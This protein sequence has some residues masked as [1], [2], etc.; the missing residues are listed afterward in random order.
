MKKTG[1]LAVL[2]LVLAML[3][4]V[5]AF[6]SS[7][8]YTTKVLLNSNCSTGSTLAGEIHANEADGNSYLSYRFVPSPDIYD[9]SS[10]TVTPAF[11][12]DWSYLTLDFD[13]MTETTYESGRGTNLYIMTRDAGNGPLGIRCASVV[14]NGDGT[15]KLVASVTG[16]TY[17]IPGGDYAWVHITYVLKIKCTVDAAN[18]VDTD[19]SILQVYVNGEFA[20]EQASPV[21]QKSLNILNFRIQSL[22]KAQS[23][24]TVCIDNAK[25]VI[26]GKGYDGN[27]TKLFDGG[28]HTLTEREYDVAYN[29]NYELPLGK[30]RAGVF[31]LAGYETVYDNAQAAFDAAEDGYEVKLYDNVSGV[32]IRNAITVNPNGYDFSWIPGD[33]AVKTTERDGETIYSFTKTDRFA[34]F[35]FYPDGEG[36]EPEGVDIPVPIGAL[37]IYEGSR[38]KADYEDENGYY[39]FKEWRVFGESPITAVTAGDIDSYFDLYPAY[40]E[41]KATTTGKI[42][43]ENNGSF[44]L[45]T[46][47]TSQTFPKSGLVTAGG[48]RYYRYFASPDATGNS[49]P[50]GTS[51]FLSMNFN[52]LSLS[53]LSYFIVEFDISTEGIAATGQITHTG[54]ISDGSPNSS[55]PLV[56]SRKNGKLVLTFG[57]ASYE[58]NAGEWAHITI[59]AQSNGTKGTETP[60]VLFING[61]RFATVEK[62]WTNSAIVTIDDYRFLPAKD[63]PE[64]A[65]LC[66]DNVTL[67]TFDKSYGGKLSELFADKTTDLNQKMYRD[68]MW[69]TD[70]DLPKMAAVARV[71][72]VDYVSVDAALA[73]LPAGGTLE[74]LAD[75]T[76]SLVINR[77]MTLITNG[78]AC[79]FTAP[80]F[81]VATTGDGTY[82]FT[83]TTRTAYYTFY[84]LDGTVLV[85]DVPTL[86][87]SMPAPGVDFIAASEAED[88]SLLIFAGWTRDG[89]PLTTVSETDVDGHFDVYPQSNVVTD[90][91]AYVYDKEGNVSVLYD[92]SKIPAKLTASTGGSTFVFA[93]NYDIPYTIVVSDI[94]IDL[95]GH[96]ISSNG[97]LEKEKYAPFTLNGDTRV[98]SSKKGG[99]LSVD[100]VIKDGVRQNYAAKD[101]N[102]DN[103]S[104]VGTPAVFNYGGNALLTL[105]TV[106]NPTLDKT[107]DGDNLT[108]TG[109]CL[110]NS[111]SKE[112]RILIDGGHYFSILGDFSGMFITRSDMKDFII[113]NAEIYSTRS[114]FSFQNAGNAEYH[115][116]NCRIY[117]APACYLVTNTGGASG[118][119]PSGTLYLSNTEVYGGQ[120]NVQGGMGRLVIGENC[121]VPAVGATRT[122]LASGLIIAS[123]VTTFT[124][125]EELTAFLGES[126]TATS[127]VYTSFGTDLITIVWQDGVTDKWLAGTL[128]T[129]TT[130]SGQLF[131]DGWLCSM[132][133]TW[134]FKDA[135]GN[136]LTFDLLPDSLV[137]QTIYAEANLT[138]EKMIYYTIAYG[139]TVEYFD[140]DSVVTLSNRLLAL[141]Q[142][143]GNGVITVTFHQDIATDRI[144][145]NVGNKENTNDVYVDL[146]GHCITTKADF[147]SFKGT[148]KY[149]IY[150]SQPGGVVRTG[151]NLAYNYSRNGSIV[152]VGTVTTPDGQTH[153]GGNL[154]VY[155]AQLYKNGTHGTG[156]STYNY[157]VN[158]G[159]YYL[160]ANMFAM[161]TYA[162]LKA[163]VKN[164]TFFVRNAMVTIGNGRTATLDASDCIFY[165]ADE[166]SL[167][168][169]GVLGTGT[170]NITDCAIY[171]P[172]VENIGRFTLNLS[173]DITLTH[174]PTGA[175]VP[176]D[177]CVAHMPNETVA[178]TDGD[179][180][181]RSYIAEY[182]LAKLSEVA[183]VVWQ[184]GAVYTKDYWLPGTTIS[185]KIAVSAAIDSSDDCY[186]WIP[187][188]EW[189]YVLD[190]GMMVDLVVEPYMAGAEITA[191]SRIER[192]RM[193]FVIIRPD[194][195]VE[196]YTETD[197]ATFKKAVE[198]ITDASRVIM[199][200]DYLD[201]KEGKI[202]LNGDGMELDINGHSYTIYKKLTVGNL[203]NVSTG[204]AVYI[205]SSK[206]GAH[207][208]SGPVPVI[209][210]T[211]KPEP[212]FAIRVSIG[213][214]LYFGLRADGTTYDKGNLLLS[215]APALQFELQ[216]GSATFKNITYLADAGDNTGLFQ[217]NVASSLTIEDCI[218]ITTVRAIF[219]GRD[220]TDW[221]VTVKGSILYIR[222]GYPLA[223]I[224]STTGTGKVEITDSV[225]YTEDSTLKGHAQLPVIFGEGV[226]LATNT[227]G[228]NTSLA[229][230]LTLARIAP[231][232]VSF[233][234]QGITWQMVVQYEAVAS[235]N[236]ATV[237][238]VQ[239]NGTPKK[240]VWKKG[241]IPTNDTEIVT[242][243]KYIVGIYRYDTPLTGDVTIEP[244]LAFLLPLKEGLALDAN[245]TYRLYIPADATVITS[246]ML[247]GTAYSLDKT[248]QIDGVTYYVITLDITPRDAASDI[249]LVITATA[250]NGKTYDKT[251]T[252]S[253]F[254]YAERLLA[255]DL[256][257]VTEQL[258]VDM[259]AYIRAAYCYFTPAAERDTAR[260]DALLE[261]RTPSTPTYGTAADLDTLS[262]VLHG[263]SMSLDSTPA[264][265][266]RVRETFGGTLTISYTDSKGETVS[267]TF[268][269]TSGGDA[270]ILLTLS[271]VDVKKTL[272]LTAK[273]AD[274][275]VI[276]E[277]SYN[278]DAYIAGITRDLAPDFAATLYAYATSAEAYQQAGH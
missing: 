163:T 253:I 34:Y 182:R 93:C 248:E 147:Y 1:K 89:L 53:T 225:L 55:S 190:G 122:T 262:Q 40:E 33:L 180:K 3:C 48:N 211:D 220:G 189:K 207:L 140:A 224:W 130:V 166:S 44:T 111:S 109:G 84:N 78:Y 36:T 208:R 146:N 35:T 235:A 145:L 261:G 99:R 230:G 246:V 94:Y 86:Y 260:V 245:F 11:T 232:T 4:T 158:G 85:K 98:Y 95:N 255:T 70:Y 176:S 66:F 239:A 103:K 206:P 83:V 121:V 193:S 219:G 252:L 200:T 42:V 223:N 108:V 96:T 136:V 152:Y 31:N 172:A 19:E 222:G 204:K 234:V 79:D 240:E 274:D 132:D 228:A 59:V 60:A 72:G 214:Q 131:V 226:R 50:M 272:T 97:T 90:Y 155:A 67:Q 119:D 171:G 258:V 250:S 271:V 102:P 212:G 233:T 201:V 88:G 203:F 164:A 254:D 110:V 15:A 257:A 126:I 173:G 157:F 22:T 183:T 71:N 205:Y 6:V 276:A 104:G 186:A 17:E 115:V 169:S 275:T 187:T 194:G 49:N 139:S 268:D 270:Y 251:M 100:P 27:L 259:L 76:S 161:D 227:L 91:C 29:E 81:D 127:S 62:Y 47:G 32:S 61:E 196:P 43:Y 92:Q 243:D 141:Q 216:G 148:T 75:C 69:S 77:P 14:S 116:E 133:G 56:F 120:A 52:R 170:L 256:D 16:D 137:G 191:S 7:A 195:R 144:V 114:I 175:K 241:V 185:C 181:L 199:H 266:F 244:T 154:T 264:F 229:S 237:S 23:E 177:F 125:S 117:L 165:F 188:G 192:V 231:E 54:R 162:N 263:A 87:G 68:V 113:R 134:T 82:V 143:K 213:S 46:S 123:K 74:L 160:S 138:R 249:A 184:S 9:F 247:N 64:G 20:F 159:T 236:T 12:G 105:G 51:G 63:N 101:S 26:Y 38:L 5:F 178:V 179:G 197:F 18:Q 153:D 129:H 156:V 2:I 267:R 198:S 202:Y 221:K 210:S 142:V 238:W 73:D 135:D 21:N 128:P 106:Y 124:S 39:V 13:M 24:A 278:L 215:G 265:A 174:L 218:V 57:G 10:T 277:G 37:P 30:K 150:S 41:K 168:P 167:V 58:L 25:M 242:G 217:F 107:F 151:G 80:G 112:R 209:E 28:K 45:P 8:D 65:T 269:Y 149:Y 273:S 118:A